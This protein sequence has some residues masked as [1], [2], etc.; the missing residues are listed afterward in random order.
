METNLALVKQDKHYQTILTVETLGQQ[1]INKAMKLFAAYK[2]RGIILHSYFEDDYW[3][4]SDEYSN[5]GIDFTLPNVCYQRYYREIFGLSVVDINKYMKAFTLLVLGKNVLESIRQ[6]MNDAKKL[7]NTDPEEIVQVSFN[8]PNALFDFIELLP[9]VDEFQK[10]KLLDALDTNAEYELSK[11][12]EYKRDLAQFE[13]Y[14][15][16]NDLI[17]QYWDSNL[18]ETDRLFVYPLYL[19]WRVTGILP[20]R[21]REFLLTPRD[22]LSEKDGNYYLTI[23]R[24]NLKG[25][26][27][28]VH[29]NLDEDYRKENYEIPQGLYMLIE[30]YINLTASCEDNVTKTLFRAEPH[31][32]QFHHVKPYTSRFYTYVNLACCLRLFYSNVIHKKYGYE[33]IQS[34]GQTANKS[35]S[36]KEIEIIHLGDTRHIAMINIILEGG[37]PTL[38]MILGGHKDIQI[39]SHYYSNISSLIECKTYAMYRKRLGSGESMVLGKNFSAANIQTVDFLP[40]EEGAKCYSPNFIAGDVKDCLKVSGDYGEIGY[41]YRCPYYRKEDMGYFSVSNDLYKGQIEKDCNYLKATLNKC[42]LGLGY[43][44]DV[45]QAL[46]RL[47]SSSATYQHFF[48]QKLVHEHSDEEKTYVPK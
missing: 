33:V 2:K 18:D 23:R 11:H 34:L 28:V 48:M 10:D 22:C 12:P 20:L 25:S 15:R 8:R 6:V 14:L 45:Q 16:F 3:K 40:I 29:Y 32:Q 43:A 30:G 1:H 37:T 24:N 5:I 9:T 7:F 31:Y 26:G 41:C 44:E 38:A 46:L 4:F 17:E 27:G 47:Q 36:D 42:R 21:P 13:S 39:S 19:W 35:L